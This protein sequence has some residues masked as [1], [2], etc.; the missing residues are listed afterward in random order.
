[1]EWK[2]GEVIVT[3]GI[4]SRTPCFSLDFGLR[5]TKSNYLLSSNTVVRIKTTFLDDFSMWCRCS[6]E[7]FKGTL[8]APV[9]PGRQNAARLH[10]E[11]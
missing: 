11:A 8:P 3:S 9:V 2:E 6:G 4:V 7:S 5:S 10:A 1:M